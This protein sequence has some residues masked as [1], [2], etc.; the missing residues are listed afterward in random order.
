MKK[1]LRETT[2]IER[3]R[4]TLDYDPEEGVLRWRRR[5]YGRPE[6]NTRWAGKVA[7]HQQAFKDKI[8]VTVRLDGILFLAH[9][10]IWAHVYGEWPKT[11][12]DH[13]DRDTLNNRINNLRKA[14]QAQN[15][16]NRTAQRNSESGIKGVSRHGQ[17]WRVRIRGFGQDF[18][19]SFK[20]KDEAVA[21]RLRMA[22]LL[23]GEFSGDA[24]D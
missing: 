15:T 9:R 20:D 5:P 16:L 14:N 22:T 10:I 2:S 24:P 4:E 12:L 7:G 13:R 6:W 23:H 19:R 17:R 8:Y 21:W 1:Q 11:G 3:L 18:L